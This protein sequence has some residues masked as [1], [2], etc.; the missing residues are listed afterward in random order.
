[1]ASKKSKI[2]FEATLPDKVSVTPKQPSLCK[3]K[4][5]RKGLNGDGWCSSCYAKHKKG[6]YLSTGEVSPDIL[7]RQRE[8][9]A[10]RKKRAVRKAARMLESVKQ[11]LCQKLTPSVLKVLATT[12]DQLD[13]PVYCEK[14]AFWTSDAICYSR[15]FITQNKKCSKCK[16]HDNKLDD[17]ITSVEDIYAKTTTAPATETSTSAADSTGSDDTAVVANAGPE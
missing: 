11:D 3:T 14:L 16:V 6:Y 5:G 15:L 17:L 2:K 10:K 9:E 1:M 12:D 4:C 13:K 8:L 7:K